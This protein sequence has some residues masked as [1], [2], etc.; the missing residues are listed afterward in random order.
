VIKLNDKGFRITSIIALFLLLF[1]LRGWNNAPFSANLAGRMLI[2]L[3]F[4]AIICEGNRW[5]IIRSHYWFKPPY[6]WL[7]RLPSIVLAGSLLTG[8]CLLAMMFINTYLIHGQWELKSTRGSHFYINGKRVANG[9]FFTSCFIGFLFFWV[10]YLIYETRYHFAR[11]RYM[12]KEK[13]RLEKE[14][15]K[16]ELHHLKEMVNPHFLFNTLNSLSALISENPRQAEIFL[17]ELTRVYRYLLRNNEVEVT[18]LTNEL[19]FMR[20]YFH[21]LKTRY[22]DGIHFITDINLQTDNYLLPP[23]TLQLLVENAVKHNR[24]TKGQPLTIHLFTTPNNELVVSN[25]IQKKDTMV[26]STRIGL[27]NINAKYNLLQK[28]GIVI[29]HTGDTFSVTVPLIESYR[30]SGSR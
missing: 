25:N 18:T 24:L 21:L 4:I 16:A 13:D 8:I 17:D 12:E 5:L 23:L 27:K 2:S 6:K 20:S 28:P 15:L 7:K 14:K 3:V 1:F 19:Q 26:D 11:L 10:F 9:L 29:D 22:G 30:E